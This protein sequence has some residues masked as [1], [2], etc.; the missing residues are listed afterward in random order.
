LKRLQLLRLQPLGLVQLSLL[1]LLIIIHLAE[2]QSDRR[3]GDHRHS[4]AD[5]HGA[6][7]TSQAVPS[8]QDASSAPN[9]ASHSASNEEKVKQRVPYLLHVIC[10]SKS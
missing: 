5:S 7:P 4:R 10:D 9:V 3:S 6:P 2:P 8:P 1:I